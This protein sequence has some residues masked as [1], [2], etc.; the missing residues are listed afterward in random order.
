MSITKRDNTYDVMKKVLIGILILIPIIVLLVVALATN[1]LYANAHIAVERLTIKSIGS[2][3]EVFDLSFRFD[4][5]DKETG[6]IDL[7][8][9]VW[10]D[11]YPHYANAYTLEWRIAGNVIYTD[12]KYEKEYTDYLKERD[13]LRK[14]IENH[15]GDAKGDVSKIDDD[16][17]E[18]YSTAFAKYYYDTSMVIEYM[19]DILIKKQYPAVCVVDDDNQEVNISTAGKI[20]VSSYCNFTLEISAENVSRTLSISIV[21]YDVEQVALHAVGK[22][23]NALNVGESV[24]L[25]PS[26]TPIDS[27]VNYTK[28]ESSDESILKVDDNGVVKAVGKGSAKIILYASVFSSESEDEI[29]YK[30][31]EIAIEVTQNGA[32]SIF[33]NQVVTAK[34]TLTLDEVGISKD[35]IAIDKCEGVSIDASGNITLL[36]SAH[37]IVLKNNKTFSI[38]K[39]GESDIAI[40]NMN[41]YNNESGY[42]LAVGENTLTL[43]LVW[44]DMLR[45]DEFDLD[46]VMWKSSNENIATVDEQGSVV[47]V[48]DGIVTI[49]AS[50]GTSEC[51]ITLNVRRKLA[52]IQLRTSDESLAVGLARETVFA[53]QRYENSDK[54]DNSKVSNYEYILVQGQPD[55]DDQDMLK[56]FYRA[57]EFE[58]ISGGEYAYLDSVESN[59]LIFK[60]S[61]EGKGKQSIVVR[62][63]VKYPKNETNTRFTQEDVTIT[64]VYGVEVNDIIDARRAVTDQYDYATKAGNV[65]GGELIFDHRNQYDGERYC[66]YSAYK[67][68]NLYSIAFASN[69]AY[70]TDDYGDPITI[71]M[72]D[73]LMFYGNVYGNNHILSMKKQQTSFHALRVQWSGITISNCI[74]RANDIGKEGSLTS[75]EDTTGF[76]GNVCEVISS[77][78]MSDGDGLTH[79]QDI[80]FEYS[81]FEN[82]KTGVSMFNADVNFKGCIIRNLTKAG[83]YAPARMIE[84]DDYYLPWYTHLD[85]HNII[86]SNTLGSFMSVAY[87]LFS[88]KSNSE[89]RFVADDLAKNEEY[90]IENFYKKGINIEVNQTGFLEAYNWQSLSNAKLISTG[91][92][93]VDNMIG[94]TAGELIDCLSYFNRFKYVSGE[95]KYIHL[96]FI[97]SGVEVKSGVLSA[98]NYLK[99]NMADGKFNE[100]DIAKTIDMQEVNNAGGLIPTAANLLS[101]MTVKMYCYDNACGITPFSTFTVNSALINR[102]HG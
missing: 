90:F 48:G 56:E 13:V 91:E 33:G 58:I 61:L 78:Y 12:E 93:W 7:S 81:I 53:S 87:E 50:Y 22:E 77:G 52:S 88:V 64:A 102:L 100:I 24:R 94:S 42:V 47:G 14:A 4:E 68:K 96:G 6:V 35:D 17:K 8:E 39:C 67:S 30:T 49:T 15:V 89:G 38:I 97:V 82:A 31:G 71:G 18:A 101:K 62:V 72:D 79:L 25:A 19:L 76:D 2:S 45:Q 27:I 86:C 57:Y 66:V 59:K 43:N 85:L 37:R 32:S 34:S 99:L 55:T 1:I 73:Q 92:A 23:D 83:L 95:D 21:G 28:W 11:V 65:I 20:Q 26:Y 10:V 44:V 3:N 60:Q 46:N 36:G 84:S 63:I 98:P 9:Y 69:F 29:R 74:F 5:I 54:N 70:E 51:S 41:F 75:A 40:D 80:N 16:Y